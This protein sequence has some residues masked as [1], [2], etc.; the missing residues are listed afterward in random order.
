M[1]GYF[2][3]I[4][5]VVVETTLG[6]SQLPHASNLLRFNA[7]VFPLKPGFPWSKFSEVCRFC[8]GRSC[9][10]SSCRTCS[11]FDLEPCPSGSHD[12]VRSWRCAGRHCPVAVFFRGKDGQRWP[13]RA[14]GRA[15]ESKTDTPHVLG[16]TG[17]QAG[18]GSV[19][20]SN[21]KALSFLKPDGFRAS[22]SFY[23]CWTLIML[24]LRL[25][26]GLR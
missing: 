25:I 19:F 7:P 5:F 6:C 15:E 8:D 9:P 2:L 23:P 16:P 11:G 21:S 1:M 18:P 14:R 17:S 24:S 10:S 22:S 4:S 13:Q 3:A 20:F 12:W 26:Y